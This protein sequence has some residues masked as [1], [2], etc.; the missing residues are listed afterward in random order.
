MKPH[1]TVFVFLFV[2]TLC[3]TLVLMPL[4]I[5]VAVARGFVDIPNARKVHSQ[6]MPRIGGMVIFISLYLAMVFAIWLFPT[7]FEQYFLGKLNLFLVLGSVVA[8]LVGVADDLKRLDPWQKL[9]MQLMAAGIAF[10]GGIR[11]DSIGF[12]SLFQVELDWLSPVVTIFWIVLVINAF[13]LIDGLDGLAG[14]VGLI[15]SG[16]L[17]Y[18]CFLHNNL[19]GMAY[20]AAIAGGLLGFLRYNFYPAS[21][22]MGDGGSYFLGYL[23]GVVSILGAGKNTAAM[24][25]LVPML[26][27]AL[28]VID[29]TLA[30]LRRFVRG[31]EIF[32][33]DK[34]HFHHMLLR[35][36]LSHRGA[37]LFLYG[38]ALCI[39]GSAL[40]FIKIRDERAFFLLLL[41]GGAILYGLARVGYFHGYDA[42]ALLPWI[43][44]VGDGIGLRRSRRSF[45]NLQLKINGARTLPDLQRH[46][47]TVMAHL[48]ISIGALYLAPDRQALELR[49]ED[50]PRPDEDER[51]Q[52]TPLY[53]SVTHRRAQPDWLWH[54]P[55]HPMDQLHRRLFRVEMDLYNAAGRNFGALVL[56]KSQA[57]SPVSHYTLNRIEHLRRSLLNA[58]ENIER[59]SG[60]GNATP[61]VV[62]LP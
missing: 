16:I 13:N 49:G 42:K 7:V 36:G 47:E 34:R 18:V 58:L 6:P 40:V 59:E 12:Y 50:G 3:L 15:A 24:T 10:A 21:V 37:V 28:P 38:A 52:M 31:Q 54:N 30:I 17:A 61:T 44:D 23:L 5:R 53:A 27:V 26:A 19:P 35:Q 41:L 25:F 60:R 45:F 14:G 39:C 51:R 11:I 62:G 43:M 57:V 4:F 55:Q 32:G 2:C 22:F 46:L 33:A 48:D 20:M 56:L 9:L 1:L 29:V 8:F